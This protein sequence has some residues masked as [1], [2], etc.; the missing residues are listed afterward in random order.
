VSWAIGLPS[1]RKGNQP[2]LK[3]NI[4]E[5]TRFTKPEETDLKEDFGH[6]RI[7]SRIC[8]VYKNL[9]F[10][11]DKDEWKNTSIFVMD[12]TKD[13]YGLNLGSS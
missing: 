9:D 6:G 5:T 3:R 10:I 12:E 1:C 4:E 8:S 2:K 13:V 11:E 7:T